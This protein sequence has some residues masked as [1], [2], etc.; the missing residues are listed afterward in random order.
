MRALWHRTVNAVWKWTGLRAWDR[1]M[2]A[3]L[4][5]AH[6]G[7]VL[8]RDHGDDVPA[9]PAAWPTRREELEVRVQTRALCDPED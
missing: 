9:T 6:G 8:P 4:Q 1:K 7:I 5:N 3:M 2:R